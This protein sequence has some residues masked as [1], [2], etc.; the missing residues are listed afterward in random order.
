MVGAAGTLWAVT[1][2]TNMAGR[3]T[4]V[5]LSPGIDDRVLEGFVE[6]L[7]L[8]C[9]A[10]EGE[11]VVV[12]ASTGTEAALLARRLSG[13]TDLVLLRCGGVRAGCWWVRPGLILLGLILHACLLILSWSLGWG[14]T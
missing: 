11:A 1:V 2:A 4:D 7:R 9:T 12:R 3:G 14:C 8:R 13:E 5:V 6:V 10:G